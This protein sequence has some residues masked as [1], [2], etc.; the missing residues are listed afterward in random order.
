M[1]AGLMDPRGEGK[2]R[3][4]EAHAWQGILM[5]VACVAFGLFMLF[6]PPR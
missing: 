3:V 4:A 2:L 5:G 6:L 1:R